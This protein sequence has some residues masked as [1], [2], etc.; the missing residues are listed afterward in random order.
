MMGGPDMVRMQVQLTEEQIAA[1]KRLA[2]RRGTSI[3]ALVRQ[4]VDAIL[5]EPEQE[6]RARRERARAVAGRF[7]S[8]LG[9]LAAEHDRYLGEDLN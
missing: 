9:D 1:L 7:R 8:G 6:E 3:A 5:R 4:G 2:V